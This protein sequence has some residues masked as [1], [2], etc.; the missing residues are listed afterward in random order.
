[1]QEAD[2]LP[3][4]SAEALAQK[5]DDELLDELRT[6]VPPWLVLHYRNEA[7]R[8]NR[9]D[10]LKSSVQKLVRRGRGSK[11]IR[12]ALD[13]HLASWAVYCPYDPSQVS[14]HRIPMTYDTVTKK[15]V[16]P[17]TRG[18]ALFTNLMHR[19]LIIYLEDVAPAAPGMMLDV[20]EH[21]ERM[22]ALR[23]AMDGR[24]TVNW[25]EAAFLKAQRSSMTSMV[26]WVDR[27]ARAPHARLCSHVTAV[28]WKPV[29]YLDAKPGSVDAKA[30]QLHYMLATQLYADSVGVLYA[31]HVLPKPGEKAPAAP[32]GGFFSR[33]LKRALVKDNRALVDVAYLVRSG[34]EGFESFVK[35]L[36]LPSAS[37]SI[38]LDGTEL[39]V[40]RRWYKALPKKERHLVPVYLALR[41]LG[42]TGTGEPGLRDVDW[43]YLAKQIL[44]NKPLA[45]DAF[46]VDRHTARG[47]AGGCDGET[48]VL[49]GASVENESPCVVPLFKRFY[50][51]YGVLRAKGKWEDFIAWKREQHKEQSPEQQSSEQQAPEQ[52]SSA[53]QPP[54]QQPEE[55]H[56]REK[57]I[58]KRRVHEMEDPDLTEDEDDGPPSGTSQQNGAPAA[59]RQRTFEQLGAGCPPPFTVPDDGPIRETQLIVFPPL[60]AQLITGKNRPDTY[61]S[62]PVG[63]QH[64][65][66]VKGPY[67]SEQRACVSLLLAE[68]KRRYLPELPITR[69]WL[70]HLVPDIFSKEPP[71]MGTRTLLTAQQLKQAQ[72]FVLSEDLVE[73]RRADSMLKQSKLWPSTRV[74][75]WEAMYRERH[76]GPISLDDVMGCERLRYD[77]GFSLLFRYLFGVPDFSSRNFVQSGPHGRVYSVD[78]ENA[79]A[80]D[81]ERLSAC[82]RASVLQFLLRFLQDEFLEPYTHPIRRTLERWRGALLDNP[83]AVPLVCALRPDLEDPMPKLRQ[84]FDTLMR[85]DFQD[86]IALLQQVPAHKKQKK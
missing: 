35:C 64:P 69:R 33:F 57:L 63:S 65:L 48:F 68:L 50:E 19:L 61:F 21:Y 10:E 73:G 7:I 72:P 42:A 60:R 17:L 67:L 15:A 12:C 71:P 37:K 76:A 36:L 18:K 24:R 39:V 29:M 82:I 84:N 55:A 4:V 22:Q 86:F 75:D 79:F 70:V 30:H 44:A 49:E 53:Q 5:L 58:G 74:V 81:D 83:E 59:K 46:A 66:F 77:L 40:A 45:M 23:K 6:V 52:Q 56:R 26:K 2:A 38:G 27:M 20:N 78:E 13:L 43:R 16:D 3:A 32:A 28:Y 14:T 41:V 80:L 9:A 25:D 47:R 54:E 1:M 8:N 34:A 11:A 51:D 31:T 62:Y 85:N